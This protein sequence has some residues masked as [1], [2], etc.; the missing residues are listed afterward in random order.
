MALACPYELWDAKS[1]TM[2]ENQGKPLNNNGEHPWRSTIQLTRT[3]LARKILNGN[4]VSQRRR[5]SAEVAATGT[6]AFERLERDARED[7]CMPLAPS[8]FIR[9]GL[10]ALAERAA[11]CAGH[12]PLGSLDPL[13]NASPK[14]FGLPSLRPSEPHQ[15]QTPTRPGP[16]RER[17]QGLA[18]DSTH[19]HP[20]PH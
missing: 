16:A 6:P 18:N 17:S 5:A 3:P 19:P 1:T 20:F 7:L 4:P 9:S 10:M 8:S 14:K 12:F 2:M 11:A 13:S 15:V